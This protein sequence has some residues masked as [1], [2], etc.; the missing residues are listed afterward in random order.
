MKLAFNFVRNCH[1]KGRAFSVPGLNMSKLC[2]RSMVVLWKGEEKLIFCKQITQVRFLFTED[3]LG[4][5]II[6][7]KLLSVKKELED[8]NIDTTEFRQS[9]T[10]RASINQA[11]HSNLNGKV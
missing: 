8:Q 1:Q 3:F 9:V 11:R 5:S 6:P 2:P 7:Q 10:K 4:T